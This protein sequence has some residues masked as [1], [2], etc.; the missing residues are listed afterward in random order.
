MQYKQARFFISSTFQDM[1]DERDVLMRRVLPAVNGHVEHLGISASFIDLRWGITREQ[2]ENG[3]V[4]DICLTEVK[5]CMPYFI[6]II[7][8]RYGWVPDENDPN[9]QRAIHSLVEAQPGVSITELE[10]LSALQRCPADEQKLLVFIHKDID[11]SANS[12]LANL[13]ITLKSDNR[14][15]CVEY[16]KADE[17]ELSAFE[18][19][20]EVLEEVSKEQAISPVN[21]ARQRFLLRQDTLVSRQTVN[22]SIEIG[23]F[24]NK[25]ATLVCALDGMGKSFVLCD[26]ANRFTDYKPSAIRRLFG[27]KKSVVV[28][29]EVSVKS[30]VT[31][32]DHVLLAITNDVSRLAPEYQLSD[33]HRMELP[34]QLGKLLKCVAKRYDVLVLIDNL[35][36]LANSENALELHWLNQKW[37]KYCRV[38][39]TTASE[40]QKKICMDKGWDLIGLGDFE[41]NQV[42][43]VFTKNLQVYGK[44]ANTELLNIVFNSST[45][46]N[47]YCLDV[48]SYALRTRSSFESLEQ[49]AQSLAQMS[50]TEFIK[51]LIDML[52]KD[53]AHIG[54]IKLSL[55]CLYEETSGLSPTELFALNQRQ[56]LNQMQQSSFIY[57]LGVFANI[58]ADRLQLKSFVHHYI[59]EL[60]SASVREN[61]QD[62]LAAFSEHVSDPVRQFQLS[63]RQLLKD[64][65][66]EL[67]EQRTLQQ[68][69]LGLIGSVYEEDLLVACTHLLSC[70][71]SFEHALVALCVGETDLANGL[72]LAIKLKH[73]ELIDAF[74]ANIKWDVISDNSLLL[75]LSTY[76]VNSG[77]YSNLL[78]L[79]GKVADR[80]E[81]QL[82]EQGRFYAV[83]LNNVFIAQWKL[84]FVEDANE[85]CLEQEALC[86]KFSLYYEQGLMQGNAS[87]LYIA[88][89]DNKRG[90]DAA[91]VQADIASALA[92]NALLQIALSH[93]GIAERRLGNAKKALDTHIREQ[94]LCEQVDDVRALMQCKTNMALASKDLGDFD[95]AFEHLQEVINSSATFQLSQELATALLNEAG[96]YLS[97]NM[98]SAAKDSLNKAAQLD[99][100]DH[101]TIEAMHRMASM[102]S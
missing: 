6:G 27:T 20:V 39:G 60:L 82:A 100:L 35:D 1:Q 65:Q 3:D 37:T 58:N 38:I 17:L 68:D 86:Q 79:H 45:L 54:S 55:G 34:M 91:N 59:P 14:C 25:R 73:Q 29:I 99:G 85:T 61:S 84:G 43:D 15:H 32:W 53:V 94:A 47:A 51:E 75:V 18:A 4:I 46:R 102:V 63:L 49:D 8:N 56:D 67:L 28:P 101:Q 83:W 12:E 98:Q 80:A 11:L 30:G 10:I 5:Q 13:V 31:T 21:A 78:T 26:I 64:S 72:K 57:R 19:V 89:G 50:S 52:D 24:K 16:S 93:R 36:R 33:V 77:H 2:A 41:S 22:Q 88:N 9:Y 44:T 81:V 97:L 66:G 92:D 74:L 76:L 40:Q 90:L 42:V 69:V 87:E 23:S 70:S 62:R 7:G 96:I 48:F 95:T 71:N